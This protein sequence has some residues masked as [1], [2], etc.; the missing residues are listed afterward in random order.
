MTDDKSRRAKGRLQQSK[1]KLDTLLNITNAINNNSSE[2]FLFS[3]LKSI[4]TENLNIAKL[5]LF[6]FD[7]NKWSVSM[8][9][10]ISEEE[11][12]K[13]DISKL[14]GSF[15]DIG[16]VSKEKSSSSLNYFDIAIPVFHNNRPLAF[17][18]LADVEGEKMEVSPI[19][20]HLRFIQTLINIIVVALENKRLNKQE[21]K[22]ASINK[23]LELARSMQTLLFPK[24]LPNT[25]SLKVTALYLPHSEVGGDYYDVIP[26]SGGRTAFCI[27]DVS[28][29]GISAALLMANFQANLRALV[30]IAKDLEELIDLCNQKIIE[31]ANFEKFITLFIAVLDPKE[32]LLTYINCG[33]QPPLLIQG[34]NV[35]YLQTG[36]TILGMFEKLPS[37]KKG[38]ISLK[39][40]DI[41]V[42]YTDGLTEM[43]DQYGNQLEAI[44]IAAILKDKK[45]LS[46]VSD[47]LTLI[48]NENKTNNG[49]DD[50][51]TFLAAQFL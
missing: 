29:K 35:K 38:C 6:T 20:K 40:N 3:I 22:Q 45:N 44:G 14:I 21:I 33:H 17:M 11:C 30:R 18:L 27:A 4:L 37:L 49:L 13:I 7:T 8:C 24:S 39:K 23:E 34:E 25:S 48:I 31:S 32:G 50:D 16:I 1:S 28:G 41:L 9:E 12:E 2:E 43:P 19:I 42:C 15:T 5:A 10:G 26:L 51:I 47:S 46:E 36:A